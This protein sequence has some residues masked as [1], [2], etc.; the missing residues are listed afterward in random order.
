MASE[1]LDKGSIER[2]RNEGTVQLSCCKAL[3]PQHFLCTKNADLH[4]KGFL[5]KSD[6]N[7]LVQS[8]KKSSDLKFRIYEGE[9]F[10]DP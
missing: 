3:N 8:Q 9:G 2:S 1:I 4:E 7:W 10:H 5:T 6:K